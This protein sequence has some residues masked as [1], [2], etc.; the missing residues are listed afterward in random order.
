MSIKFSCVT[1]RHMS[2]QPGNEI[3]PPELDILK[4]EKAGQKV[5]CVQTLAQNGG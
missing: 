1:L 5:Y 2:F 4:A 3:G